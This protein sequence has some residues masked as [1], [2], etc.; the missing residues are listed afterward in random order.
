VM[1]K[2]SGD[3]GQRVRRVANGG[4]E[5]LGGS[6]RWERRMKCGRRALAIL[7]IATA[8]SGMAQSSDRQ[9]DDASLSFFRDIAETQSY[10]LGHP[11]GAK[12]T[13]DG[14]TAVFLRGG[15]RDP[16]LRLYELDVKTKKVKELLTPDALLK[17]NEE[18][19]TVEERARRERMR[20]TLRG[21]TSFELS[22]DGT[23]LLVS[24]SGRLY[25]V[26]RA[27][28]GVTELPSTDWIDPTYSKDGRYVAAVRGDEL[29]VIDVASSS[30]RQLT[31]GATETIT[32]GV[33]E[34]VAQEEMGRYHGY[35]WSPDSTR[36][37]YQETD[38]S[39]VEKHYIANPLSPSEPPEPYYYPRAGT[40]NARV[41]LGIISI[42]GGP[43]TW[44]DWD[45]E[46]YPYL[47]RVVWEEN[48]PLT[49]LVQTRDQRDEK[50]LTVD[51][52]SGDSRELLT[53]RDSA[54]LN[55]DPDVRIPRWLESGQSFLW[56]TERRGGWQL[57][58]R[59]RDGKLI[60]EL[61]PVG[62]ECASVVDVD[63]QRGTVITTGGADPRE[64]HLHRVPLDG[65][66]PARITEAAGYHTATF[67]RDHSAYLYDFDLND[68][69]QG[70]EVRSRNDKL[71][72]QVPSVAE[73][74]PVVPSVELTQ[75]GAQRAFNASIVR[76]RD[77]QRGRKYPVILDVYAGPTAT[78]VDGVPRRHLQSQWM[79]DRGFIIV[80]LDGRGTPGR[81][82]DWERVIKGD[83]IDVALEDQ[84]AGLQALGAKY[85]EL[86]MSRVGVNGWSFGGYFAAM[87]TLRRPNVFRCGVAGAPVVDWED[88]DTHY[89]ERYMDLP[90]A[91][92]EGYRKANVLT[93]ASELERPLLLIHGLTDDN[94]YV[95]HTLKLA[96]ALFAAGRQYELLPLVGTHLI[97]ESTMELRLQTRIME[98]LER[99]LK[100]AK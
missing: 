32:H 69:R 75:V 54:W 84:V 100:N 50:L 49:I 43:T 62:C 13:P 79:A 55:L 46:K 31:S 85:P 4:A 3:Q 9:E 19:L 66:K 93:Y 82:R 23:K 36:L 56:T 57:E 1:D 29:Y 86:D 26:R 83:L 5:T 40:P 71:L 76:P 7:A 90:S 8:G 88:Y 22:D 52:A 17:G 21:F 53:E 96:N 80:S 65:G 98:F 16:A 11:V 33:A 10:T 38:V 59:G 99:T 61:T 67:A 97:Y 45:S 92:P 14:H 47:A 87:A 95:V 63:E 58:L 12:L 74:P 48:S 89:T 34:F 73:I 15:P 81:G 41:R 77:F 42:T 64:L 2:V 6:T 27:D 91:N 24:L 37:V 35:W 28:K 70:T 51:P 94:V 20:T 78:I 18:Q 72:A 60:R 30:Q 44:I 68:G 25:V 39:G